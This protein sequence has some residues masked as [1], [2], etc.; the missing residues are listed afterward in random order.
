M[1]GYFILRALAPRSRALH[2]VT[3]AEPAVPLRVCFGE[4]F[5]SLIRGK[6][7][8][9]YGCGEG[10]PCGG[11][12]STPTSSGGRPAAACPNGPVWPTAV[13]LSDRPANPPTSSSAK[14]PS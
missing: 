8:I 10:A 1:L 6:S 7:I 2:A 9:D 5:F 14:I 11:S 3:P 12:A 13:R 4:H